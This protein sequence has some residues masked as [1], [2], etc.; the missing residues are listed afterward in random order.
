MRPAGH[1]TP[2][3]TTCEQHKQSYHYTIERSLFAAEQSRWPGS[4]VCNIQTISDE[5]AHTPLFIWDPR[6]R[7][8]GERAAALVQ[9]IDLAPT[10]LDFFGAPIPPDMQGAP[11]RETVAT[12]Q[13]VREAGLFGIFGA[14]VN[15]TDGRYVYMRG[16]GNVAENKPL[17]E[18]TLMPTHMRCLFSPE[19]LHEAT[20]AEPLPF[21][22]GAPVLKIPAQR[23]KNRD[24]VGQ[25]LN[26]MLFDLQTDPQQEHP[27]DDP[28]I[29]ARMIEHLVRLMR[30]NDA[31][32]EQFQR[33]G[34]PH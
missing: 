26:T 4:P 33:L 27:I 9:T 8:A 7:R 23:P 24:L 15:V 6:C 19:E 12:D 5:V 2:Y 32:K 1:G 13:P 11:L 16:P 3:S 29:E 25:E 14:H 17:F 30:E 31:P 22:K 28:V 21:S 34:L 18:Y 10:L 20:L